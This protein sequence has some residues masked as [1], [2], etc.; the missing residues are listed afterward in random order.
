ML[1]LQ[2]LNG[3]NMGFHHKDRTACATMAIDISDNMHD[4]LIDNLIKSKMLISIIVDD[5]TDVKNVH[6][7][8]IYFQTII[9]YN[10]PVIYFYKLTELK[11][12]SGFD[13]FEAM[14]LSWESDPRKEFYEYIQN[15]LIGF[16]SDGASVNL[17]KQVWH[18][19][20]F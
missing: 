8:V 10:N 2:K 11:S 19:K 17:G 4:I 18:C 7:K 20:F 12:G 3:L 14:R 13:G 9:E 1:C 15:H 16:A 5:T 6:F